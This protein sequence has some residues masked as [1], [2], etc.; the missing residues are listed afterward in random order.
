MK[1][2]IDDEDY[3]VSFA[4]LIITKLINDKP[5]LAGFLFHKKILDFVYAKIL[6]H[7]EGDE[8]LNVTV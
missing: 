5:E 3:G 7:S 2:I 1:G 4:L 6:G 8:R